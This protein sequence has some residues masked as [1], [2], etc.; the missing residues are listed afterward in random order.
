MTTTNLRRRTK[1]TPKS[2]SVRVANVLDYARPGLDPDVWQDDGTLRPEIKEFIF[3]QAKAFLDGEPWVN[4]FHII[5]SLTSYQYNSRSDLD[6]HIIVDW[7]TLQAEYPGLDQSALDDVLDSYKDAMRAEKFI[8]PGTQHPLEFSFETPHMKPHI[9]D[10]DYN[11]SS[12]AWIKEPRTVDLDMDP[13]EIYQKI[14]DDSE[15]IASDLDMTI[16]KAKRDVKNIE[17]LKEAMSNMDGQARLKFQQRLKERTEELEQELVDVMQTAQDI[18]DQRDEGYQPDSKENIRFKYLQKFGYIWLW[19]TLE[20]IMGDADE[21]PQLAP[22]DVSQVKEVIDQGITPMDDKRAKRQASWFGQELL[23]E[24]ISWL[25]EGM[26]LAPDDLRLWS[27]LACDHGFITRAFDDYVQ[28]NATEVIQM[29]TDYSPVTRTAQEPGEPRRIEDHPPKL[30]SEHTN[31]KAVSEHTKIKNDSPDKANQP[32][33][34]D[35]EAEPPRAAKPP[36]AGGAS[37]PEKAKGPSVKTMKVDDPRTPTPAEGEREGAAWRWSEQVEFHTLDVLPDLVSSYLELDFAAFKPNIIVTGMDQD[38]GLVFAEVFVEL[39]NKATGVKDGEMK[40]NLSAEIES[41]I[42]YEPEG[43]EFWEN[44]TNVDVSIEDLKV[45]SSLKKWSIIDDHGFDSVLVRPK[46]NARQWTLPHVSSEIHEGV[47]AGVEQGSPSDGSAEDEKKSAAD[48]LESSSARQGESDGALRSVRE[49]DLSNAPSRSQQASGNSVAVSSMPSRTPSRDFKNSPSTTTN[50]KAPHSGASGEGEHE[51][52]VEILRQKGSDKEGTVRQVREPK[53]RDASHELQQPVHGGLDV[54]PVQPESAYPDSL[55]PRIVPQETKLSFKVGNVGK[56]VDT[57]DKSAA[58]IPM[59][60]TKKALSLQPKAP[61]ILPDIPADLMTWADIKAAAGI[62]GNGAVAG[63]TGIPGKFPYPWNGKAYRADTGYQ[64]GKESVADV[65]RHEVEELGNPAASYI[66]QDQWA[67]FEG[68]PAINAMWVTKAKADAR[69]YGEATEVNFGSGAQVIGEDGDGGYLVVQARLPGKKASDRYEALGMALPDPATMCQGHCEGTGF[70]PVKA[71]D[72]REVFKKLWAEQEAKE[73][74]EDGWH[75]VDCPDCGG[76]GKRGG[77]V[78]AAISLQPVYVANRI[79]ELVTLEKLKGMEFDAIQHEIYTWLS[80]NQLK[81]TKEDVRKIHDQLSKQTGIEEPPPK[82][83]KPDESAPAG[84]PVMPPT[85]VDQIKGEAPKPAP[86]AEPEPES[87]P[88]PGEEPV[89]RTP[90][91]A[92]TPRPAPKVIG[93]IIFVKSGAGFVKATEFDEWRSLVQGNPGWRTAKSNSGFEWVAASAKGAPAF[94]RLLE[95][96]ASLSGNEKVAEIKRRAEDEQESLLVLAR[97]FLGTD[98]E[99]DHAFLDEKQAEVL[100][101][102]YAAETGGGTGMS[103]TEIYGR[104]VSWGWVKPFSLKTNDM[105]AHTDTDAEK[106]GPTEAPG[107][108]APATY[109]DQFEDA[110][111]TGTRD[112]YPKRG[113]TEPDIPTNS[114]L[115]L[116]RDLVRLGQANEDEIAEDLMREFKLTEAQAMDVLDQVLSVS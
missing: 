29:V 111:E 93:R 73:H 87:N 11:L 107:Q 68:I 104:M 23:P 109:R 75:F 39:V 72:S 26:E 6:V 100:A 17:A 2:K 33:S 106:G 98:I 52:A 18:S 79:L 30:V 10:G 44:L 84:G 86:A 80:R 112:V 69:R 38:E 15:S 34:G 12:D 92:P 4:Q 3:S 114:A 35:A 63:D 59:Q 58:I 41:G 1:F 9:T 57:V 28:A 22:E 53:F 115:D 91:S 89:V 74:S 50:E 85:P 54:P 113:P 40:L 20:K 110:V 37:L 7:P 101:Q 45:W 43:K 47:Y 99:P 64:H 94:V 36:E 55:A 16:G 67:K 103:A 14:I 95:L 70:V 27:A 108:S 82:E 71:D 51:E 25:E 102:R 66:G 49:S 62:P 81:Y 46:E 31:E 24:V 60:N 90:P 97:E 48:C 42:E 88:A 19:K 65:V 61:D 77:T 32:E 78:K 116:A 8:V 5:G 96:E 56:S 76:S 83:P 13:Q 21:A 105:H